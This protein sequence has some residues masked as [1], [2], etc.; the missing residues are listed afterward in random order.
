M[1][2]LERQAQPLGSRPAFV[3][4]DMIN[5][6]TD[7]ESPLGSESEAVVS[8]CA[9]ALALFRRRQL[10]VAFTTVVYDDPSQARVF[11]ARIPALNMLSRGSEAVEVDQRLAPVA[12]EALIEKH[13][14]SGFFQTELDAWLREQGCDS[15]VIGGLTTSGCVR[16]TVVDGLQCG[17]PVWVVREAVGDRN[18]D[19]HRANLHDMHAKYADVVSIAELHRQ[20]E[21][22]P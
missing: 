9:E 3:L 13:F 5:A 4:I 6:F 14:A 18:L 17:Y 11:R 15:L 2:D 12:G 1:A 19:A 22:R 16:A 10:P 21:A 7:P 20:L 8:A